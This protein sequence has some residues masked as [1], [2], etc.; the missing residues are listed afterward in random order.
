VVHSSLKTIAAFLTIAG[1]ILYIGA[2]DG[3]AILGIQHDFLC[4]TN[5]PQKQ[6]ADGWELT[7][8]GLIGGRFKDGE[9]VNDYVECTILELDQ[10][11]IARIKVAPRRQLFWRPLLGFDT[12]FMATRE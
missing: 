2:E 8:R 9:M 5:N 11:S 3:G 1:E 7:L 10:R 4:M 12:V 6:N